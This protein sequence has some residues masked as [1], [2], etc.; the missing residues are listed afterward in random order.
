MKSLNKMVVALSIAFA[1]IAAN[2]EVD[3]Y[4]WWMVQDPISNLLSGEETTWST[5]RVNYGGVYDPVLN[6]VV[7]GSW[8]T[9]YYGDTAID[10]EMPKGALTS[11]AA[12]AWGFDSSLGYD[13]FIF[14]LLD[15]SG[16]LAGFLYQKYDWVADAIDNGQGGGV[17]SKGA[18]VLTGVVPEPTSGLL[19][20][21]GLAALALRRRRRA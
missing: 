11:G 17:P 21:F 3:S 4:I 13:S 12:T 8:L 9:M 18:F 14:E 19:S 1:A 10:S 16:D 5:A 7:D 2:A 15:D 6:E 20:L